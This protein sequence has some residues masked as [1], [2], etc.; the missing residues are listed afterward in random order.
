MIRLDMFAIIDSSSLG[1]ERVMAQLI[2][3]NVD[4]DIVRRLKKRAAEHGRSAEEEHRQLLRA[5]LRS[6][7]LIDRLREMPDAGSDVDFDRVRDFPRDVE[8]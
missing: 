4:D 5:A 1:R 8:L 2:V 7:G 6:E 3:R